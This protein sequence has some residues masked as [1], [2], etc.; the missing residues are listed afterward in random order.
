VT[1][2]AVPLTM[3]LAVPFTV[4]LTL[5]RTPPAGE[6]GDRFGLALAVGPAAAPV[7]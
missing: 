3:P 6:A 4:P 1:L 7:L 2:A 5:V